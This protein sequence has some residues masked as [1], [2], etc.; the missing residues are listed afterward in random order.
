MHKKPNIWLTGLLNNKIVIIWATIGHSVLLFD[1]TK[2]EIL[3][4]YLHLNYASSYP[5]TISSMLVVMVTPFDPIV[6]SPLIVLTLYASASFN[7]YLFVNLWS[8]GIYCCRY[9]V[10]LLVE[11]YMDSRN[12]LKSDSPLSSSSS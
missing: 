6:I 3:L 11:I 7:H 2:R 8:S 4:I 1:V 10:I 9:I 12:T 5:F